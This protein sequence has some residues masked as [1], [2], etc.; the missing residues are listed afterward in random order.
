MTFQGRVAADPISFVLAGLVWVVIA[1]WIFSMIGWMVQGEVDGGFGILA[2]SVALVLG[3]L[4]TAPPAKGLTPYLFSAAV[5]TV[6]AYPLVRRYLNRRALD[7]LDV[8]RVERA[9]DMLRQRPDNVSAMLRIA[10][11]LYERGL[12]EHAVAVGQRALQNAPRSRFDEEYR[13]LGRW[14]LGTR[15]PALFGSVACLRCRAANAP[16]TVFCMRCR[17]PLMLDYVRGGWNSA[18]AGRKLI[19][20]WILL[21]FALVG[22]P[23]ALRLTTTGAIAT[24]L[25]LLGLGVGVAWF[26]FRE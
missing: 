8:E 4:T 9:D 24:T 16:G 23:L 10:R 6:I 17:S 2:C 15:D 5:G 25:V 22:V 3:V 13:E 14:K 1:F 21:M 26:A 7:Q 18:G 20:V 11:V 19:A 12:A